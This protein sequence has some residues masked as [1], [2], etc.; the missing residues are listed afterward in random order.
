MR[1]FFATI[2]IITCAGVILSCNSKKDERNISVYFPNNVWNR[3]AP[4]DAKFNISNIKKSYDVS[5][6]LSV[7]NG[8]NLDYIPLEI[9]LTSPSGQ[10]NIIDKDIIIKD[11]ENK[12]I[13]RVFGDV[14]TVKH[15]IYSNKEF[16][17][18]G[19]YSIFIQN[20]TQYYDLPKV[21]CLSFIVTPS[22]KKK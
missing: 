3:F 13:G 22:K 16:N 4:M 20:R 2:F 21:K 8:F 15:I 11:K 1:K 5:V 6:E 10:T 14:W 18:V 12:H 17:E 9:V 7:F 19:E